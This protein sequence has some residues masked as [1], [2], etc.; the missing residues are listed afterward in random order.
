MFDDTFIVYLFVRMDY[1]RQ[2]LKFEKLVIMMLSYD[3]RRLASPPVRLEHQITMN[4]DVHR[5]ESARKTLKGVEV[6]SPILDLPQY[7]IWT[8]FGK[9]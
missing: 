6:S 1:K 9:T 4:T 5:S 7:D 2:G 3:I 8:S